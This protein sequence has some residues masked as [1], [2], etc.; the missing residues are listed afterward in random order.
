MLWISA[1]FAAATFIGAGALLLRE[2]RAGDHFDFVGWEAEALPNRW[3]Y[4][5]GAPL[6][7]DIPEDEALSRYFALNDRS[8]P[9]AL[10]L[11]NIAEAV[12]EERISIVLREAGIG[13]PLPMFLGGVWPPVDMELAAS[14]RVLVVSPRGRIERERTEPLRPDLGTADAVRIEREVEGDGARSALVVATGGI[15]TY[16]SIVAT[17]DGYADTVS[18]AAHEWVH[19]YLAPYPLGR[20]YFATR[21]AETINETVADAVGNEVA[22]LAIERWGLPGAPPPASAAG[23]RTDADRVFRDLRTE[24]DTLLAAGRVDDAERRMEAVR[25][26]LERNGLRI[27]RINQAYFAWYGT[28]AARPD[29]VDP[30][31]RQVR[32]VR[33]RAGSLGAF[34]EVMRGVATRAEVVRLAGE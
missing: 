1:I 19:H 33:E 28:Y 16:P 30:L 11:E 22:S 12:I 24:V 8:S 6:R 32:S 18:A 15:A 9:E 14:P 10:R 17:G 26:E 2:A 4:R 5:L 20:A 21:E 34:I 7:Q 29:S 27:R 31:G 13:W 3:L 23:P 25:G